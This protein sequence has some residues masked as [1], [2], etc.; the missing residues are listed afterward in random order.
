MEVHGINIDNTAKGK[1]K[2][3]TVSHHP[4]IVATAAALVI[5]IILFYINTYP[6]EMELSNSISKQ[7]SII[8]V[9]TSN[10]SSLS[11]HQ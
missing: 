2:R 1:Q 10:V 11:F 7:I 9:E 8:L 4:M 6:T 5:L 3:L